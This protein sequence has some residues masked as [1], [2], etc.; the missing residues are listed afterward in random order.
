MLWLTWNACAF[1]FGGKSGL[2]GTLCT[3]RCIH[4]RTKML[5]RI[6]CTL[7]PMGLFDHATTALHAYTAPQYSQ[8]PYEFVA[9][10]REVEIE[11]RLERKWCRVSE[12]D[13]R[14][15]WRNMSIC[16]N[17]F[18]NTR[19]ACQLLTASTMMT[20]NPRYPFWL[21][22]ASPA[23]PQKTGPPLARIPR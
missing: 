17:A 6:P 16:W 13:T 22:R 1:V 5:N 15:C 4:W 3:I 20:H 14:V 10:S 12:T 19:M 8:W 23:P 9:Q 7:M 11:R 2:S 18:T 21:V